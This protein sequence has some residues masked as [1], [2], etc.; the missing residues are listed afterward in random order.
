V[1]VGDRLANREADAGAR[2]L[3]EVVES[4]ERFEDFPG[5]LLLEA[6]AVVGDGETGFPVAQQAG[7]D[8]D[9]RRG[10][11]LMV[12]DRVGDD[13][14][15]KPPELHAIGGDK[16]GRNCEPDLSAAFLDCGRKVVH[17][18][19]NLRAQV[20]R[21]DPRLAAGHSRECEKV[22]DQT[23]GADSRAGDDGGR[24]RNVGRVRPRKRLIEKAGVDGD[25]AQG[26]LE[27]MRGD[28]GELGKPLVGEFEFARS[29]G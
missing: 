13:I 19:L 24:P 28:I 26:L 11:W 22:L 23:A 20:E 15:E 25:L 29:P 1:L 9:R 27:V 12:L 2:I 10:A 3:V 8:V 14:L 7:A 16:N 21:L 4:F 18:R 6:D 5:E 17:H